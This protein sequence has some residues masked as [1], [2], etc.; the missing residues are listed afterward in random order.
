MAT[1]LLTLQNVVAAPEEPSMEG[2]SKKGVAFGSSY[3]AKEKDTRGR[4]AFAFPFVLS[5][6]RSVKG[7]IC[8]AI[9]SMPPPRLKTSRLDMELEIKTGKKRVTILVEKSGLKEMGTL[10]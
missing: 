8:G 4:E 6:A 2:Y 9:F 5:T 3:C 1:I 7:V 10:E